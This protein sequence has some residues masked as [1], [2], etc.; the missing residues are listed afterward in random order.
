MFTVMEWLRIL[1]VFTTPARADRFVAAAFPSRRGDRGATRVPLT[2]VPAPATPPAAPA[3]PAP[4][5]ATTALAPLGAAVA[6]LAGTITA[7]AARRR[8]DAADGETV[9][10]AAE[11]QDLRPR[12]GCRRGVCH[13][14]AV[15]MTAGTVLDTRDGRSVTVAAGGAER[16]VQ[17]CV[18]APAGDITID[19]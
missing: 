3:A 5:A 13:R 12:V 6:E 2:G 17:I 7:S 11:R 8:L 16:L 4:P 14:C 1:D 19:L 18:V 15:A 10:A 9:L